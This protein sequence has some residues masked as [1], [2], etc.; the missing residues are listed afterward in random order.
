LKDRLLDF[1]A[2][3]GCR[4]DLRL[5]DP[6]QAENF[7]WREIVGGKLVCQ[8]CQEKYPIKNGIPRMLTNNKKSLEV[9]ETVDGFG[10]EWETYNHL[11]QNTYMSSRENFFDFIHP[12]TENYFENKTILDAGCG[13]GRFLRLG[14]H[15]GSREI[16][17]LDLSSSVEA[18]YQNTFRL[19]NAHV[20]QGDIL[21]L[22]LKREFDYI[23][24]IGVLQFLSEPEK[25][26]CE[27]SGLLKPGGRI[28]IWVY[29]K[30]NNGWVIR[31]LTPF[32]EKFTSRLPRPVLLFLSRVLGLAYF[33][34]LRLFYK[35]T[36][37]WSVFKKIGFRLPY[38]DY[39]YYNLRLSY[40]DLSS[41]IFD[42]LVPQ[43]VVY[44]S[45]EEV[46]EWFNNCHLKIVEVSSR[47]NMSWRAYGMM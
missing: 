41:V 17:G 37:E 27:L 19:P 13:M 29:S 31:F 22:P 5:E 24:S 25:G 45:K 2:C 14:A 10:Y 34:L 23:F 21:E 20:V 32:R 38:N 16:I 1:L 28:S 42:H 11:I 3:P 4:G 6:V 8:D 35:P 18:A 12:V 39:F 40:T 36:N 15:F 33:L 46:L 43:L 9:R 7:P 30:E 44:L 47:N 26:F